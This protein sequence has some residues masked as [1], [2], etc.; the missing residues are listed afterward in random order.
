MMGQKTQT[1]L[2]QNDLENEIK[3][4]DNELIHSSSSD[5]ST[6]IIVYNKQEL[7]LYDYVI[8]NCIAMSWF[9][10]IT[11]VL[12]SLI[13][14]F[15][16]TKMAII[17]I[18]GGAIVQFISACVLVWVEKMMKDRQYYYNSIL[19]LQKQNKICEMID[20]PDHKTIKKE[21]IKLL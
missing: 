4:E 6:Y 7:K 2:N 1:I 12:T 8:K 21:L 10:I 17:S 11:I 3:N 16:N 18:I 13:S 14:I 19:S 5:E 20:N 9:G 15:Y